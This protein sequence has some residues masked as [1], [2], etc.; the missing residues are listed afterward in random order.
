MCAAYYCVYACAASPSADSLAV[1]HSSLCSSSRCSRIQYRNRGSSAAKYREQ[2]KLTTACAA[3]IRQP[4]SLQD[5]QH[6]QG[7][8]AFIDTAVAV[9]GESSQAEKRQDMGDREQSLI[10]VDIRVCNQVRNTYCKGKKCRKHTPHKVTQ[11]KTGKASLFA[12]GKRRYDR[13]QSGYGGQ[14]KPVFHK[15]A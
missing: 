6:P 9:A 15:S 11:Y 3:P 13:K 2:V 14:T 10:V 7:S 1:L 5:G 4:H 12:Q 8:H